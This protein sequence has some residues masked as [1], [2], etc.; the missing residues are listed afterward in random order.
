MRLDSG[1]GASCVL[2]GAPVTS[3]S[4]GSKPSAPQPPPDFVVPEGACPVTAPPDRGW[5]IHEPDDGL[6]IQAT[7]ATTFP[8]VNTE[9]AE[10]IDAY[11]GS[12]QPAETF[13]IIRARGQGVE[14]LSWER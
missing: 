9:Q 4:S 14:T 3:G 7:P 11:E 10:R 8:R 12:P 1:P 2:S 5:E 13:D 6:R